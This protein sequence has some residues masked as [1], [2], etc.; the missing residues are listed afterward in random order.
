MLATGG[1]GGTNGGF[2][3]EMVAL[4]GARGSATG[5]E[6]TGPGGGG[7]GTEDLL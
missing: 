1:F 5:T 7:A 4:R 6:D 2:C 3:A